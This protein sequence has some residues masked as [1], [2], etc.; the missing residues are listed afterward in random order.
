MVSAIAVSIGYSCFLLIKRALSDEAAVSVSAQGVTISTVFETYSF[1]L[2]LVSSAQLGMIEGDGAPD[3]NLVIELSERVKCSFGIFSLFS[4]FV[5]S[6]K[7]MIPT[8]MLQATSAEIAKFATDLRVLRMNA[9]R[10]P[11]SMS[12]RPTVPLHVAEGDDRFGDDAIIMKHARSRQPNIPT[13]TRTGFGRKQ[14]Q[15]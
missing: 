12:P 9:L 4:A 15:S 1:P 11:Q 3:E 5:G 14:N 10:Y 7:I 6:K 13:P 8:R 2:K